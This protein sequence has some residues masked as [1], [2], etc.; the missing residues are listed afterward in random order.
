MKINAYII[1]VLRSCCLLIVF[2]LVQRTQS[3]E[4]T[5]KVFLTTSIDTNK[6]DNEP[7]TTPGPV[8]YLNNSTQTEPAVSNSG[9]LTTFQT[10]FSVHISTIGSRVNGTSKRNVPYIR[11][12]WGRQKKLA[13]IFV[14][15]GMISMTLGLLVAV[16]LKKFSDNENQTDTQVKVFKLYAA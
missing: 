7:Q 6:N 1:M 9:K 10:A 5:G 3:H 16:I 2:C 14:G 4:T 12:L 15:I 8:S 13:C 11:P